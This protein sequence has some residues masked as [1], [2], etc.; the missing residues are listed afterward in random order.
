M[1]GG[2]GAVEIGIGGHDDDWQA[3]IVVPDA[4][5]QTEA[6]RPRHADI[7]DDGIGNLAF[8]T[9]QGSVGVIETPD[10]HTGSGE[11][12]FQYPADGAIVIYY[13]NVFL[14]AHVPFST[15]NHT[16]NTVSPGLEE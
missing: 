5:Q 6:I 9:V 4:F 15:G 12:L 8:K 14:I 2:H 7:R 10:P 1:E 11:R 3:G 16:L 13:P